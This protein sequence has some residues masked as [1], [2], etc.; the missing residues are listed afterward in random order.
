MA[1]RKLKHFKGKWQQIHQEII[2]NDYMNKMKTS[3]LHSKHN[4]R[5]IRSAQER[6]YSV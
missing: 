2:T 6:G 3:F 5:L 1:Y 4:Q